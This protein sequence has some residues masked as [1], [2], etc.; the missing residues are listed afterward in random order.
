MQNALW[1]PTNSFQ[2]RLRRGAKA[3]RL[4]QSVTSVACHVQPTSLTGTSCSTERSS[5]VFCINGLIQQS[6]SLSAASQ[7]LTWIL[8]LLVLFLFFLQ[9]ISL[10][11]APLIN[12]KITNEPF[13]SWQVP[14]FTSFSSS[15]R[16]FSFVSAESLVGFFLVT[17]DA[18]C[19]ISPVWEKVEVILKKEFEVSK[20]VS[21]FFFELE[22]DKKKTRLR[23]E[24]TYTH[25]FHR[26]KRS[27]A[28]L[29]LTGLHIQKKFVWFFKRKKQYVRLA[30]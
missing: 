15:N 6:T 29:K 25:T 10:S 20:P 13:S 14:K 23:F 28:F 11:A 3:K 24:D 8:F 19:C 30:K 12:I 7:Q 26:V 9:S 22:M 16:R 1:P 17:S 2:K 4:R 5:R 21:Y 18:K 27:I